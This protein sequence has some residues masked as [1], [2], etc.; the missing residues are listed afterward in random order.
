MGTPNWC[1]SLTYATPIS[2]ERDPIPTNEL[3]MSANHSSRALSK[4]RLAC[5]PDSSPTA[6]ESTEMS[7]SGIDPKFETGRPWSPIS[8]HLS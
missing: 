7:A 4:S 2:M 6:A 5:S 3:A 8:M 1:R